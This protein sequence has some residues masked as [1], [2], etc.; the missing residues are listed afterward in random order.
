M[1]ACYPNRIGH[2]FFYLALE[3]GYEEDSVHQA[4]PEGSVVIM[5]SKILDITLYDKELRKC[6]ILLAI[7]I[8]ISV[9]LAAAHEIVKQPESFDSYPDYYLQPAPFPPV[10][11]R[12]DFDVI[13]IIAGISAGIFVFLLIY[14]DPGKKRKKHSREYDGDPDDS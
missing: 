14:C 5:I 2:L 4:G 3:S 13:E 6:F 9:C 1:V 8:G 11:D 10:E 12:P 7:V